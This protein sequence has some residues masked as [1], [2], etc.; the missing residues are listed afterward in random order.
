MKEKSLKSNYLLYTVKQVMAIIFPLISFPYATR[1]LGV[2][3][4]GMVDYAKSI[5]TYFVLLSGLGISDYAIREGSPLRDNNK[6]IN[7]FSSEIIIINLVSTIIAL[8]LLAIIVCLKSFSE[9]RTLL[10]IFSLIIPFTTLGIGWIYN[11]YE[12]YKYITIRSILFQ[13]ISIVLLVTLVKNESDYYRYAIIL[14]FS[15]AGSNIINL[16]HSRKFIKFTVSKELE[17][18]KH[19]KPIFIIFGMTVASQLYLYM[20][21]TMLGFISGTMSVGLYTAANKLVNVIGTLVAALRTIMLPRLS[22]LAKDRENKKFSTLNDMTIKIMLLIGLPIAG[23]IFCLSDIIIYLFCGNEFAA[24][25]LTLKL[26]VPEIILSA[27]N[28]YII[29]QLFMPLKKEKWALFSTMC[30]ALVNL[31]SNSFLIPIIQ[32]NGAAIGTCLAEFSVLIFSIVIG[33]KLMLDTIN[34]KSILLEMLKYV[35]ATVVMSVICLII[36]M[37]ISNMIISTI[38]CIIFGAL[39]YGAVLHVLRSTILLEIVNGI[40]LKSIK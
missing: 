11:I 14:V 38:F 16:F 30:G 6:K 36:I 9:Y 35:I 37:V 34:V 26:L 23:G 17:F 24:A 22:Y 31:V 20:D 10:L 27:V 19:F 25:S 3:G 13:I 39:I 21:I 32:Q 29:Y 5:V 12:E 15:S 18:K 28:G 7:K 4:I 2:N 33:R 8:C 1:I 40:R